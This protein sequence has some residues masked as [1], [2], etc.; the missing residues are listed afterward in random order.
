MNYVLPSQNA[1][2]SKSVFYL[3]INLYTKMVLV[4][5]LNLTSKKS[6]SSNI[7]MNK[8]EDTTTLPLIL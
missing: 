2:F 3:Y 4:I 7:D 6:H 5:I 8:N 1:F